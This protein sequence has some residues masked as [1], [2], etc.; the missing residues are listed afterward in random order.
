MAK[1]AVSFNSAKEYLGYLEHILEDNQ[2]SL[3]YVQAFSAYFRSL[4]AS[5]EE[6]AEAV[7]TALQDL[8]QVSAMQLVLKMP[9][10]TATVKR[11]VKMREVSELVESSICSHVYHKLWE[12][13]KQR[14][15]TEDISLRGDAQLLA[16][17]LKPSDLSL[18]DEL[19]DCPFTR[20]LQHLRALDFYCTP[21]EKLKVLAQLPDIL[22]AEAKQYLRGVDPA[23]TWR[24]SPDSFFAMTMLLLTKHYPENLLANLKFIELLCQTRLKGSGASYTF[25]NLE[26]AVRSVQLMA[27]RRRVPE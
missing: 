16:G 1:E 17:F 20:T 26:A 24:M 23:K 7:R 10:Y 3:M 19:F 18:D 2:A 21:W 25:N 11:S 15:M 6:L 27:M 12:A 13:F 14:V 22:S 4:I 5:P 8:A 9:A